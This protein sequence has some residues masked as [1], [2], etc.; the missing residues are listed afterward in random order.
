MGAVGQIQFVACFALL[1]Q[2]VASFQNWQANKD[3]I[4][5]GCSGDLVVIFCGFFNEWLVKPTVLNLCIRTR[6]KFFNNK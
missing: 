4:I 3:T 5:R 1:L 6:K 2:I